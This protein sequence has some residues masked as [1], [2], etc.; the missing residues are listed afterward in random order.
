MSRLAPINHQPQ[1][2]STRNNQKRG[3]FMLV[4]DPL[5]GY[6]HEVPDRP[7]YG[8]HYGG[9]GEYVDPGMAELPGFLQFL[10]P[11]RAIPSVINAFTGGGSPQQPA[12]APPP[13]PVAAQPMA[14]QQ[15]MLP[16]QLMSLS[17]GGG[18]VPP[19]GLRAYIFSVVRDALAELE[20]EAPAFAPGGGGFRRRRRRR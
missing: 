1:P 5:S 6:L 2:I 11:M 18:F 19:P 3:E 16:Q 8:G 17:V 12:Q 15:P 20:P 10:D 7:Y 14:L 4:Q 13:A 9:Y